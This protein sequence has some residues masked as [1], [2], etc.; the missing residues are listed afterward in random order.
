MRWRSWKEMSVVQDEMNTD[1]MRAIETD[2]TLVGL[3][4]RAEELTEAARD[5]HGAA[6]NTRR[7]HAVI[8]AL[9]VALVALLIVDGMELML[10][11][12]VMTRMR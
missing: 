1:S 4:A 7:R 2:A 12:D 9:L 10:L 3:S 6:C 8:I 5:L 11:V